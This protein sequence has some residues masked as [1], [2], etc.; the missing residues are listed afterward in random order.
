MCIRDRLQRVL[1]PGGRDEDTLTTLA[2]RLA[3]LDRELEPSQRQQIASASGGHTPATLAGALLR[4]YDPDAIAERTTGKLGASPEE[5]APEK[6]EATRQELIAAACAPFDKP[7]LRQTLETL[8]QETEYAAT[9]FF[10]HG[11]GQPKHHEPCAQYQHPHITR[12]PSGP[13]CGGAGRA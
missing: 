8:K 13:A 2:A 6:Y 12:I 9:E 11:I 10:G 7:A 5:V 1:F 3:R 4:A